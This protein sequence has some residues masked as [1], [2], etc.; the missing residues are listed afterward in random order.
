MANS[1]YRCAQ[2]KQYRP[3]P[4]AKKRGLGGICEECAGAPISAQVTR[5]KVSGG[6]SNSR[7]APKPKKHNAMPPGVH[8]AI[9]HRDKMRCRFCAARQDLHVHHVNLKSQGVDHQPHNLLTLCGDH[10]RLVHEDTRY[11]RPIL[12][13]CL[14]YQYVNGSYRTIPQVE[15]LVDKIQRS[16]WERLFA[17]RVVDLEDNWLWTGSRTKEDGYGRIRY[18]GRMQCTHRMAWE[19]TNGPIPPGLKVLH[20]CDVPLCFNPDHLFLGTQQTNMDPPRR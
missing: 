5:S 4:P 1:K 20:R 7:R 6:V 11:W 14:W 19:L 17:K 10:H 13:A 2:C 16:P 3:A 8:D 18:E 15:A 9:I 12:L